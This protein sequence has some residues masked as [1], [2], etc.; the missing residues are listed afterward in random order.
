[1]RNI[2]KTLLILLTFCAG[3]R[4]SFKEKVLPFMDKYCYSCHD[5]ETRKGDL[6][7]ESLK[8]SPASDDNVAV[9][10]EV[11]VH[12]REQTMPPPEKRKQPQEKERFEVKEL[13]EE[14]LFKSAKYRQRLQKAEYANYIE[15]K[16]LFDGSVKEKSFTPARL[17]R[18]NPY[19]FE[20]T[21]A[22]LSKR[23]LSRVKQ[24]FS[25]EEKQQIRDYASLAYADSATLDTMLR[26]AGAIVDH[27]LEGAVFEIYRKNNDGKL[28]PAY[29]PYEEELK[30]RK[31]TV[32][33]RHPEATAKEFSQILAEERNPSDKELDDAIR[34]QFELLINYEPEKRDFQKYRFLFKENRQVSDKYES[35]R[36]ML[37]AIA[38]SPAAIYRSELGSGSAD[39]Y[40]RKFLSPADLAFAL[41]FAI[42]DRPE[43]TLIQAA[44][45]GRLK[46]AADVQREMQRILYDEK[47]AKPRLLRFFHEFFFYTYAPK[48][49][50]DDK[51]F[52]SRYTYDT[53]A[54]YMVADADKLVN[55][56][57]EQD[58]DVLR[59]LLTTDSYFVGHSADNEEMKNEVAAMYAVYDI[60]KDFNVKKF[61]Y[62]LEDLEKGLKKKITAAGE[63]FGIRNYR[64]F[65]GNSA[66]RLKRVVGTARQKGVTPIPDHRNI[67]YI[68]AYNLSPDDWDF[69][70]QQPAKMPNSP[71]A[72]ILTHPAWLIAYSQ[73]LDTD[74]VRRGKW[75]RE[76]LL[77]GTIP[78][79]PVTVD[80]KVPEDPHKTLRERFAV[81]EKGEC[82]KCHRKMNPL[83]NVFEM[84][85]DFGRYREQHF[86]EKNSGRII[87][88]TERIKSMLKRNSLEKRPV[89]ISGSIDFSGEKGLDA[90]VNGAV[91]MM[92]RLASSSLVRQSFIRHVFRFYMGRNESYRDSQVLIAADKAYEESGGSFKALLISLLSSDAF[93]YRK[94]IDREL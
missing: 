52:V 71:R 46:S 15:H 24:P 13:V 39:E 49:F 82:W 93:L 40:G 55:F 36:G 53:L 73:N 74:P 85:D 37:I 14:E 88:E 47:T 30:G 60:I 70:I 81:V 63:K 90:K 91:E 33:P 16:K 89:D 87:L 77:A 1:M 19:I 41:S 17:W 4:A 78:D 79:L 42:G 8:E 86:V 18:R 76:R 5:S 2:L 32:R 6:D 80:A 57:I 23:D 50:K 92:Q 25:L 61:P 11:M 69:I 28:P 65:N 26:N 62:N 34:K 56:I 27:Q 67:N 10:M 84:Y 59:Q 35:L 9:W 31:K 43:S 21:R 22:E 66:E 68:H 29:R 45:E 51:R 54:Q 64:H 48:V 83:G 3:S 20:K 75:L 72:G 12:L 58:R 7:L 44:K 38:I 94:K